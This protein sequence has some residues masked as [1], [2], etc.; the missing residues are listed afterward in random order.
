MNGSS[1]FRNA[2]SVLAISASVLTSAGTMVLVTPT[3]SEA[4]VIRK[5]EVRGA[6]RVG[7]DTVKSSLTIKPGKDFSNADIDQSIKHLYATGFFSDVRI[8]VSG[9]TLVVVV[10][11]NQLINQIV[12]NGNRKIKDDKLVLLVRSR[13]LGPYSESMIES[14]LLTLRRPVG[15]ADHDADCPRGQ[16]SCQCGLRDQRRRPH[17]DRR[18]QFRRQ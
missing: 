5:I 7:A 12:F 4:A 13:P 18:H 1:R 3:V 6:E 8:S 2:V 16:W 10:N 9:G 15:R 11:E 14:D 17:E